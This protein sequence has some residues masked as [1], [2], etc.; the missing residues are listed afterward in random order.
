MVSGEVGL[1]NSDQFEIHPLRQGN[2]I[3]VQRIADMVLFHFGEFFGDEVGDFIADSFW[4]FASVKSQS[5]G[6]KVWRV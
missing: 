6:K 4:A 1:L 2:V 3:I 5:L